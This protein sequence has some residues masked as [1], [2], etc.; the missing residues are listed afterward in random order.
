[1]TQLFI[2]CAGIERVILMERQL[3]L[4]LKHLI[5][6]VTRAAGNRLQVTGQSIAGTVLRPSPRETTQHRA[7][8]TQS[9]RVVNK[10]E[11]LARATLWKLNRE[12]L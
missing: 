1:M 3:Q 7:L 6:E 11:Q 5:V 12:R 8:D 9:L 4:G 2:E 10:L